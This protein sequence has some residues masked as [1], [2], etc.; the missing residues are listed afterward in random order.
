MQLLITK[1][2]WP[3]ITCKP[4]LVMLQHSGVSSSSTEGLL[5]LMFSDEFSISR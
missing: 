2:R 3:E 4:I 5:I 1:R